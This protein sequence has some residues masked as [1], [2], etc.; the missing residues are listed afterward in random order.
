M[1]NLTNLEVMLAGRPEIKAELAPHNVGSMVPFP[2]VLEWLNALA[3]TSSSMH[4]FS[5]AQADRIRDLELQVDGLRETLDAANQSV[6]AVSREC[7][8]MQE[9]VRT[10]MRETEFERMHNPDGSWPPGTLEALQVA[11]KDRAAAVE[12]LSITRAAD[13]VNLGK[14]A[15]EGFPNMVDHPNSLT[16]SH[17]DNCTGCAAC[18]TAG[19]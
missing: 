15:V 1:T 12:A 13:Y 10:A 11:R 5:K 6:V 16:K 14:R 8:Q 9:V 3:G 2:R 4:D 18:E 17:P 19:A 7:V